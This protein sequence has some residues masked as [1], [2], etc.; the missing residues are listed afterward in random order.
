L[1]TPFPACRPNQLPVLNG[2][3]DLT[4]LDVIPYTPEHHITWCVPFAWDATAT[5]P[6]TLAWLTDATRHAYGAMA[7]LRGYLRAILHGRTDLHRFVELYEPGGSGKGTFIR[8]AMALIG[9]RNAYATELRRLEQSRFETAN[10]RGKR[11]IAITDA[12]HYGGEVNVL[13]ALTG[14]DELPF[15][16]KYKPAATGSRM[17]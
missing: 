16:E 1:L 5:C 8:L 3:L 12:E 13:K 6:K 4:T 15:E 2:L 9:R 17:A 7:V 11:L 14:G 10:L